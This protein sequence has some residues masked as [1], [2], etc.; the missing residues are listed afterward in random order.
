M[1]PIVIVQLFVFMCTK[2]LKIKQLP[3]TLCARINDS[4]VGITTE[5]FG[6]MSGALQAHG[7]QFDVPE[8]PLRSDQRGLR[9][10]RRRLRNNG[11]DWHAEDRRTSDWKKPIDI[12]LKR[13]RK[14]R[15]A[16]AR[17]LFE[18]R[19]CREISQF[20]FTK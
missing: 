15:P 5:R 14:Y 3:L 18:I 16:L 11:T 20:Q 17:V 12:L 7:V 2:V 13:D 10:V 6:A 1:F 9:R 8:M 19:P 4:L